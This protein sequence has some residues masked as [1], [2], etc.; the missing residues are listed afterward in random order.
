VSSPL[1]LSLTY[2]KSCHR[3]RPSVSAAW[4]RVP[5][6]RSRSLCHVG[7]SKRSGPSIRPEKA[8]GESLLRPHQTSLGTKTNPRP[9]AE[10][11]RASLARKWLLTC[12]HG[13]GS[14]VGSSF[15][16]E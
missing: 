8:A 4:L 15:A 12:K 13:V 9:T 10:S 1:E 2:I 3:C 7:V 5:G 11:V 14:A 6:W 16:E